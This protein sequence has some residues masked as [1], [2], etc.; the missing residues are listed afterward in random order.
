MKNEVEKDIVDEN[1]YNPY[2]GVEE[3]PKV[4]YRIKVISKV[5]RKNYGMNDS[6]CCNYYRYDY[7]NL[8][9]RVI[10]FVDDI[11]PEDIVLIEYPPFFEG[12]WGFKICVT[13]LRTE[14]SILMM[15]KKLKAFFMCLGEYEPVI[16]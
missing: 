7:Y 15:A 8:T 1:F 6:S 10:K 5:E 2:L 3:H 9:K 16:S 14:K 11:K 13:N 12:Y 4:E